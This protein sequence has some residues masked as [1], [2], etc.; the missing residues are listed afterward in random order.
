MKVT[1]PVLVGLVSWLAVVAVGS[2]LVWTVISQVGDGLVTAAAPRTG[3]SAPADP[4]S[5]N[6]PSAQPSGTPSRKPSAQPSR[7]PSGQPPVQPSGQPSVQPGGRSTNVP[8]PSPPES[9]PPP[10]SPPESSPPAVTVQRATWD[11][12]GGSVAAE[13]RGSAIS[14]V[15]AQP[16]EGYRAE[17]KNAG[18]E[19]LE[20]EFEGREEESG[21]GAEVSAQCVSGLPRFEVET[22]D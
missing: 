17:V 20:V 12:V 11:G 3:S 7:E 4:G 8:D 21:S 19:E 16:D 2:T 9:S 10:S 1:R 15:A 22:E 5:T 14:L 18:P 13:C 6:S